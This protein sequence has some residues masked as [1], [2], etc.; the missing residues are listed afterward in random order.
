M[1]LISICLVIGAFYIYSAMI[2]P[3]YENE[4]LPLSSERASLKQ[5]F[6]NYE[7]LNKQF[8]DIVSQYKK[9][10]DLEKEMATILPIKPRYS[11]AIN[12]AMGLARLSNLNIDSLAVKAGPTASK[13]KS[14]S[15]INETGVLKISFKLNGDYDNFKSFLN[16]LETNIMI[17]DAADF[18]IESQPQSQNLNYTLTIDTYY[19]TE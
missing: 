15:L 6:L 17:M 19:Q 3:L 8:Q 14:S 16:Y 13:S 2:K 7:E 12:Q 9:L 18:K 11:Y 5:S 4:I 1:V 10:G